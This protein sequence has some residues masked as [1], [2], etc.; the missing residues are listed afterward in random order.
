MLILA[1][2]LVVLKVYHCHAENLGPIH[3]PI[4]IHIPNK[5]E[6][7]EYYRRECEEHKR[8][9]ERHQDDRQAEKENDRDQR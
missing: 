9:Q 1:F 4:E 3:I 6:I 8:E 7:A 2:V 5:E